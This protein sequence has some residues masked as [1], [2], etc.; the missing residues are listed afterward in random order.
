MRSVLCKSSRLAV[1]EYAKE[2]F[3]SG[4]KAFGIGKAG[5][6]IAMLAAIFTSAASAVS[7]QQATFFW[8]AAIE[9]SNEDAQSSQMHFNNGM[10]AGQVNAALDDVLYEGSTINILSI[11]SQT[12]VSTSVIGNDNHVDITANQDSSNSGDVSNSGSVS[13]STFLGGE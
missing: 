3:L 1:Q 9:A 6:Q 4:S 2:N 8:G 13:L 11:G 12:V 7:S 10:V 5:I